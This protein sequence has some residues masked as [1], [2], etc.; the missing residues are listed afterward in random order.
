[1]TDP[2]H[3]EIRQLEAA[4]AG[5]TVAL[6]ALLER[7]GPG[8]SREIESQ[9]GARWQS[10]VDADDVMQV[11]YLE[12]FL[13]AAQMRCRSGPAFAGWLRRIAENNL[14]DAVRELSRK[15]RPDGAERV[16]AP[17]GEESYV[18]LVE[19]LGQTTTTPSR[20]AARG[21]AGRI[22]TA[23]LDRLPP[24]YSTVIRMYDLEGRSIEEVGEALKRSAGAVH[25][26]RARA[27]ERL[28]E[29]VGAETN[30]FSTPA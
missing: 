10:L 4:A 1:M 6:E 14:R 12:A 5:D 24:D 15:K 17:V 20:V 21:E 30:F 3:D 22:I 9:I 25:M 29:M 11:T 18:A 16:S 19:L 7:H 13:Q 27:H 26:L 28:R 23:M 2:T 8:I